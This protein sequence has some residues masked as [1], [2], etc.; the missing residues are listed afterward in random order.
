MDRKSFGLRPVSER[1][2]QAFRADP[3]MFR[4]RHGD[5]RGLHSYDEMLSENGWALSPSAVDLVR[6]GIPA[7]NRRDRRLHTPR[8]TG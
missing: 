4:I 5:G 2:G 7:C 8:G 3:T 6:L 1:L